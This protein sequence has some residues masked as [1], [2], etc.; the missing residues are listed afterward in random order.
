MIYSCDYGT[1]EYKAPTIRQMLN[2][3][4]KYG[5]SLQNI[6]SS[7]SPELIEIYLELFESVFTNYVMKIDLKVDNEIIDTFDKVDNCPELFHTVLIFCTEFISKA[8]GVGE[9]KKKLSST[10]LPLETVT[11]PSNQ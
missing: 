6:G 11:S 2:L 8:F 1:I 9:D 4:K 3:T 7:L 5:A 10:S